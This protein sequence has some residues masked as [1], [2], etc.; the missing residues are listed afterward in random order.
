M[1]VLQRCKTQHP[2][3]MGGWQSFPGI[4]KKILSPSRGGQREQAAAASTWA[5][6]QPHGPRRRAW[7][8]RREVGNEKWKCSMPCTG[9]QQKT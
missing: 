1:Q 5:R 4:G 9:K 7:T 3:L 8:H 6:R 2:S